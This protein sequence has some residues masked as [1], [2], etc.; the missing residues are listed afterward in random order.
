MTK[1]QTKLIKDKTTLK[2]R[3]ERSRIKDLRTMD[4]FNRMQHGFKLESTKFPKNWGKMKDEKEISES[5]QRMK[6]VDRKKEIHSNDWEVIGEIK[7]IEG[8][9]SIGYQ[10]DGIK[11]F[12]DVQLDKQNEVIKTVNKLVAFINDL[13]KP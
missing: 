13:M 6:A 2:Q 5:I 8:I 9:K 7:E 11:R 10:I 3:K 4:C 12:T 1:K